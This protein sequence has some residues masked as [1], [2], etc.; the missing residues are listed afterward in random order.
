MEDALSEFEE[1]KALEKT[2]K[3]E[4]ILENERIN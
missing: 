1:A 2:L 3:H 4:Q